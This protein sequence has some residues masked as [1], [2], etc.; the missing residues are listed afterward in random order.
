ML[1]RCK[2]GLSISI[3]DN[4]RGMEPCIQG[5]VFEMFYKGE[6]NESRNGMGLFIVKTAVEKLNGKISIDTDVG[7]GATIAVIIPE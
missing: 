7:R 6:P 1:K 2:E 5:R 3:S 4:G